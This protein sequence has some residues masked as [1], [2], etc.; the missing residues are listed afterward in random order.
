M[1]PFFGSL[2]DFVSHPPPFLFGSKKY[3]SQKNVVEKLNANVMHGKVRRGR[4]DSGQ[5]A[6]A[7]VCVAGQ[8]STS[9]QVRTSWSLKTSECAIVGACPQA[10]SGARSDLEEVFC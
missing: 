7:P 6:L 10:S 4:G 5:G 3:L 9:R 8:G 1:L 2:D